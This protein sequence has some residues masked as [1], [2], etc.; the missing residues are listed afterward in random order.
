M[1][2]RSAHPADAPALLDIYAPYVEH[3]RVTFEYDVPT[4]D[5]FADRIR[6]TLTGYPYL[7]A[8]ENGI[9]VGYAYAS[10]FKERAAY[11]WSAETTIYVSEKRQRAGIG[12]ALY[13]AL[14]AWLAKQNVC[15]LYACIAF[16]N[17]SSIAFHESFGYR[18][19][20]HFTSSGYKQGMWVDIVWMEKELCPHEI[21]PKPFIPFRELPH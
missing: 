18:R 19:A 1:K 6:R 2:I 14:E 20:A 21:P 16:P 12:R 9:L 3:T 11:G 8:E 17:P 4:P 5:D 15:N 7:V 13:T 10:P